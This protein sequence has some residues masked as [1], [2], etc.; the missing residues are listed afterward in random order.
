MVGGYAVSRLAI[1]MG[2]LRIA[3]DRKEGRAKAA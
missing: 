1:E 3:D 2:L